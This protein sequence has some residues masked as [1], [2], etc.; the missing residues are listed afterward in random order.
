MALLKVLGLL[1]APVV[2][3]LLFTDDCLI[4]AE[5]SS[6]EAQQLQSLL[7]TYSTCSGQLKNYEK[8]SAF[9]SA[10]SSPANNTNICQLLGV[11]M[12][13]NPTK[14]L[15]L[16]SIIGRNTKHAFGGLRDKF[17]TQI[18]NWSSHSLS[19]GC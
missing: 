18:H 6:F 1:G 3:H 11:S 2:T 9:F 7:H 4:F 15:G 16:P 13:N 14:Y 5:A 17:S 8:S 12:N 10:N 19:S